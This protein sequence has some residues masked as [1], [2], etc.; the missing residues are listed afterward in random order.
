MAQLRELILPA[1]RAKMG[2]W[3]YYVTVV[4]M[5]DFAERVKIA[6]DIHPNDALH[7]LMQRSLDRGHTNKIKDFLLNDEQH[8]FSSMVVGVYGGQP[9]WLELQISPNEYLK[10][11][12]PTSVEQSVG[13]L[14]LSGTEDLYA[15][16]GQHRLV[17][18]QKA[19]KEKESLG[20]EQVSVIF[21]SHR[22][23]EEGLLRTRRLF[24]RLNRYAKPVNTYEKIALDED[25]LVAIIV[26]RLVD[27]HPLFRGKK[28]SASRSNSLGE[29]D[30]SSFTSLVFVYKS[31]DL[32]LRLSGKDLKRTYEN[33]GIQI[34]NSAILKN[35]TEFKR[36]RPDEAIVD[37]FYNAAQNL[38]DGLMRYIPVLNS[39]ASSSDNDPNASAYRNQSGGHI[40]FRPIGIEI[41]ISTIRSLTNDGM[42]LDNALEK[43][44][45]VPMNLEG[46]PWV[47]VIWNDINK[48][49]LTDRSNR[50]VAMRLLHFLSKDEPTA[51]QERQLREKLAALLQDADGKEIDGYL[52]K[53]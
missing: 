1:L 47:R 25:D 42:T 6:R 44:S 16:D 12:A 53:K 28:V 43:I 11:G 19:I 20:E 51:S 29:T 7:E 37:H 17:G 49:M 36:F 13:I 40:L 32:F 3:T 30:K 2:D 50:D 14:V 46:K 8:F 9:Q 45:L 38:W 26:R 5:S 52:S 18:I 27:T 22:K 23:T 35:W 31:L 34:P 33:L 41:V 21:V 10:Q 4:H 24:A 48:T 15:I 39:Y